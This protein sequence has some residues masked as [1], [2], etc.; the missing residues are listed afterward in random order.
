MSLPASFP[1]HGA[2]LFCKMGVCC[3]VGI[4]AV[5]FDTT[6]LGCVEDEATGGW[7]DLGVAKVLSVGG[8]GPYIEGAGVLALGMRKAPTPGLPNAVNRGGAYG[9]FDFFNAG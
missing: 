8:A 6:D 5:A 7:A 1:S 2:A 4:C 3:G 9:G